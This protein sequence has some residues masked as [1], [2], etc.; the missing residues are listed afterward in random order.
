[1]KKI[2]F[3]SLV[4]G[5]DVASVQVTYPP[6]TIAFPHIVAGGDPNGPHYLT[7]LQIVNNN[8][9]STTAHVTL[10]SDSG[11]PLAVLLDGQDPHSPTDLKLHR[12]PS[13]HVHMN[14]NGAITL[15]RMGLL[16]SPRA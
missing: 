13:G 16:S 10:F 8:S 1:M 9:A 11:S 7:L 15:G 4:M 6:V 14:I 12:G 2:A 3:L 5:A